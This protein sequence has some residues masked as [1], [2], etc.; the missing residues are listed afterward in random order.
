M[1]Q[2]QNRI[3]NGIEKF[4]NSLPHPVYIF[5]IL[6]AVVFVV[7]ALCSSIEFPH[8][9]TGEE[10]HIS[11]LMSKDGLVW[12]LQSMVENFC[13]LQPPWRNF[14]SH[15]GHRY[16]GGDWSCKNC[17]QIQHRRGAQVFGHSHRP[18]GRHHG[19]SGRISNLRHHTATGRHDFQRD[20]SSSDCMTC[21]RVC[22]RCSRAFC[23]PD[24][25]ADRYSALRYY[26]IRCADL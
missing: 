18:A 22:R 10:Q 7:S 21:H 4:G 14:G 26:R 13:N 19:Q 6:T 16:C 5:I 1:K 20:G 8:P 12:F 25:Y 17:H 15:V 9:N 3:W 24:G 2:K 11:N 23:Q